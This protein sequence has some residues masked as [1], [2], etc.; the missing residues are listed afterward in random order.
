MNVQALIF[1]N[2]PAYEHL[3]RNA[4]YS[5]AKWHP[6]IPV[7]LV[8]PETCYRGYRAYPPGFAKTLNAEHLVLN[9]KIDKLIILGAD[10]ITTGKLTEFLENDEDF[11][12]TLDYEGPHPLGYLNPQ[13][14]A[15]VVCINNY[16]SSLDPKTGPLRFINQL[17]AYSQGPYYEQGAQ[18]MALYGKP[19]VF[20]ICANLRAM[21]PNY[22]ELEK[23]KKDDTVEYIEQ[24]GNR[25]THKIIDKPSSGVVYN[26]RSKQLPGEEVSQENFEKN[27]RNFKVIDNKLMT[28]DG[29]HIKV[30]H[31]CEGLGAR[32]SNKRFRDLVEKY[33]NWFNEETIE[34]LIK[35]CNCSNI[36]SQKQYP[37]WKDE[38]KFDFD[39][40]ILHI[41]RE[42]GMTK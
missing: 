9:K 40:Y 17:S 37:K 23:K 36:I 27:I 29:R 6:G 35:H 4:A 32:V 15:D 3:A 34:F 31:I 11:L 20:P 30:F 12:H 8:T 10:T 19:K 26:A 22:K 41:A 5:F 28:S 14:N 38:D 33:L 42:A 16:K 2:H 24:I 13:V 21:A 25:F 39:Q 1:Y 7:N 18:N